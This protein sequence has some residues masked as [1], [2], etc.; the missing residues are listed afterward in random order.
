MTNNKL[1]KYFHDIVI[2]TTTHSYSRYFSGQDEYRWL[3]M[4][5]LVETAYII[6]CG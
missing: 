2:W 6:S 3:E 5:G 1:E 4:I